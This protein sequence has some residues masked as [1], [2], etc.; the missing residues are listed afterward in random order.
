MSLQAL[1]FDVD[2]TL[3]ETERD[4]HRRAFNLAF[5]SKQLDWHW[6][7]ELYAQLLTVTGGKERIRYYADKFH[8]N[9]RL[10]DAQISEIHQVKTQRFV[11]MLDSGLLLMRSGVKRLL[12]EARAARFRLAIVTTTSLPNVL[13]LLDNQLGREARDWFDSFAAGSVVNHKKPAADIYHYALQQLH[14]DARQCIAFEDS[15]NGL[16]SAHTA[17]VKC[18]VTPSFYTQ[19]EKFTEACLVVDQLGEPGNPMRVLQGNA[20]QKPWIDMDLLTSIMREEKA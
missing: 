9:I 20:Y 8:S 13:A 14:L 12:L 1:L 10:T 11:A 3:A 15:R 2:G 7:D 18:I 17:G 5:E 4:G 19:G 16:L 6:D